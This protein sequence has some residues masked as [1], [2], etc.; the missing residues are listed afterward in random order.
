[1]PSGYNVST[2][3]NVFDLSFLDVGNNLKVNSLE[4]KGN[5][6]DQRTSLRDLLQMPVRPIIRTRVKWIKKVVNN[7][8]Q[9][10]WCKE[11]AK[12]S[13]N[14]LEDQGDTL[15][16]VNVIKVHSKYPKIEEQGSTSDTLTP[17]IWSANA[18]AELEQGQPIS[19]A[20]Q[21]HKVGAT[22]PYTRVEHL[23]SI[24]HGIVT[25]FSLSHNVMPNV[26]FPIFLFM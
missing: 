8:I 25:P 19:L 11:G 12:W 26:Y 1:M 17:N 22:T 20:L 6:E 13:L 21:R 4:E 10:L 5:D 9:K 18:K 23:C 2:T 15:R 3:F 24:V 16:Y 7:L 14:I